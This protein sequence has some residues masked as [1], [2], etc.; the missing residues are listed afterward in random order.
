VNFAILDER[1]V[2]DK[3]LL[4]VAWEEWEK[5]DDDD[6]EDEDDDDGGENGAVSRPAGEVS[7]EEVQRMREAAEEED[8][9][10]ESEDF[11]EGWKSMRLHFANAAD[12]MRGIKYREINDLERFADFFDEQG[13]YKIG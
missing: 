4:L 5:D 9:D 11:E 10:D 2:V 12:I 1:S 6:D 13:V 7:E 3:T 8:D